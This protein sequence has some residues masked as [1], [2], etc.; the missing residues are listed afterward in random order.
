[1]FSAIEKKM[2]IELHPKRRSDELG[3]AFFQTLQTQL[4]GNIVI[5]IAI[6]L[7]G[8]QDQPIG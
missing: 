7:G 5:V 1:V 4:T 8:S 6:R 3:E 2:R